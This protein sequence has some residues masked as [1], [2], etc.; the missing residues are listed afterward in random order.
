MDSQVSK[1]DSS[2]SLPWI[3]CTYGQTIFSQPKF[4]GCLDNQILLPIVL[5][6]KEVKEVFFSCPV[7]TL[8][9][10][11]LLLFS[12]IWVV[13]PC[14]H[15]VGDP[16]L[17]GLVSFV[18]TLWAEGHKTKETYP[19][20]PGSPTPC[21]QGLSGPI[22]WITRQDEYVTVLYFTYAYHYLMDLIQWNLY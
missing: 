4:V 21:K 8:Y 22:K 20:R 6:Y 7:V 2:H 15:G 11:K 10:L 19:T 5:R 12:L 3:G 14:L 13:R 9:C 1:C 18:F 17:V 16:G